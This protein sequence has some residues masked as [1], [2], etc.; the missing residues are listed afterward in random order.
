[1][2]AVNANADFIAI[3]RSTPDRDVIQIDKYKSKK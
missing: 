1:M 2:F 3:T